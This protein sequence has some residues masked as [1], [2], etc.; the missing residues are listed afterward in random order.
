MIWYILKRLKAKSWN[1]LYVLALSVLEVPDYLKQI[2]NI[3]KIKS[4][5]E[6]IGIMILPLKDLYLGH[7]ITRPRLSHDCRKR[8][9]VLE[10]YKHKHH[11]SKDL[12]RAILPSSTDIEV[13]EVG[14]K[15]MVLNGNGRVYCLK[16]KLCESATAS[17]VLYKENKKN[18]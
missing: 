4:T 13:V 17:V 2:L 9:N 14:G 5:H 11:M 18:E 16:Q 15:Y 7:P 3:A 6:P 10:G 8:L 1:D 12:L